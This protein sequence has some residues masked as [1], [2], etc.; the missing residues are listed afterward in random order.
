[1][2]MA[3]DERE[4]VSGV[5]NATRRCKRVFGENAGGGAG[6]VITRDCDRPLTAAARFFRRFFFVSLGGL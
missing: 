4:R 3:Y 6:G 5:T 1:M 2:I